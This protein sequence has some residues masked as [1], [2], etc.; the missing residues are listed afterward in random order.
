MVS[1]K[2]NLGDQMIFNCQVNNATESPQ[3]LHEN[4]IR[5]E[6]DRCDST[7]IDSA[8]IGFCMQDKFDITVLIS[9]SSNLV[10]RASFNVGRVYYFTSECVGSGVYKSMCPC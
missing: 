4:L 6:E 3:D 2:V 1:I 5:L 10:N 9:N 7:G 8:F